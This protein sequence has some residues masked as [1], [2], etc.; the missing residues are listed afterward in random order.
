MGK[1]PFKDAWGLDMLKTAHKL[2]STL[3]SPCGNWRP[4]SIIRGMRKSLRKSA[5]TFRKVG[6]NPNTVV[7]MPTSG[8]N[9]DNMLEPSANTPW[10]EGWK[11]TH[12]D[13]NASGTMLHENLRGICHNSSNQQ[14]LSPAPPG[15]PRNERY[16]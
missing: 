11:V 12:K 14:A 13:G 8:W 15:C 16:W 5:P 10:F 3:I 1:R 2:L 4:A 6:D 7:F 9:G